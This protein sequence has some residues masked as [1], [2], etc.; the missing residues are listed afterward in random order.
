VNGILAKFILLLADQRGGI[1]HYSF[2]VARHVRGGS[3]NIHCYCLTKGGTHKIFIPLVCERNSGNIHFTIGRP[4]GW[5]RALFICCCQTCK[6]ED[7]AIFIL[8]S[9]DK[10]W[11]SGDIHSICVTTRQRGG[12]RQFSIFG[13]CLIKGWAESGIVHFCYYYILADKCQV[14]FICIFY[15]MMSRLV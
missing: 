6:G 12:I 13:I 15:R 14:T 1:R 2:V 10:R 11:N 8:L 5:N 4:W 7:Q 3:G 9:P